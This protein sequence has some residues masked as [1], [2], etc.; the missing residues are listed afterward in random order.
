MIICVKELEPL[1]ANYF[2]NAK[3]HPISILPTKNQIAKL[4]LFAVKV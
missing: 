1:G 3:K 2:I 4:R